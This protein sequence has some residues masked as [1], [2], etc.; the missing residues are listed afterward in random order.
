MFNVHIFIQ[1]DLNTKYVLFMVVDFGFM[2]SKI[3]G[4]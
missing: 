3:N 4:K 2:K 1:T